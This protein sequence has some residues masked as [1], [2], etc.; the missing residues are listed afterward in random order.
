M[1]EQ[2]FFIRRATRSDLPTLGR[3]GAALMRLH[4]EIDPQ[5]FLAPPDRPEEGYAWFLGTQLDSED[6][7]IFV[8]QQ[9][10]LILGYVYAAIEP[11]SWKELRDRCGYVHDVMVDSGQRR[12]GVASALMNAAFDWLKSHGLPRVVLGTASANTAAQALFIRLGF[13]KT[14]IEMTREL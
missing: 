2:D 12:H 1:T 7:V 6:A 11:M 9:D 5:R 8:A 10:D 13:R 14:M 4:Y 3:L